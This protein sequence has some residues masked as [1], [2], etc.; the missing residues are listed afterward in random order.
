MG[1]GVNNPTVVVMSTT[2]AANAP[3]VSQYD[4]RRRQRLR[5]G[6]NND[7]VVGVPI[8][9]PRGPPMINTHQ[10]NAHAQAQVHQANVQR[11]FPV[12]PPSRQPQR[13]N[14]VSPDEY[15]GNGA[16]D[17]VPEPSAPPLFGLVNLDQVTVNTQTAYQ[18]LNAPRAG[19]HDDLP[20]FTVSANRN[21]LRRG[22]PRDT[23]SKRKKRR[24]TQDS[25]GDP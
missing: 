8:V 1:H 17:A 20:P 16:G 9:S 24:D 25:M 18:E 23:D 3:P 19:A 2:T 12:T 5:A 13:D 4:Q 7:A 11:G 22:K 14:F 21:A 10:A 6:A 15:A